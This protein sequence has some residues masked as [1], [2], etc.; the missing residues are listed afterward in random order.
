ME[1]AGEALRHL[2]L[3]VVVVAAAAVGERSCST[4]TASYVSLEPPLLVVPLAAGSRTGALA[5]AAGAFS[6]SVLADDQAEVAVRAAAPSSAD[7]LADQGIP[8]LDPPVGS[9]APGVAG[10]VATFWCELESAFE[11]GRTL[12]AVGRVRSAVVAE[13]GHGPLVRYERRY[14][15][16][17]GQIEVEAEAAYPL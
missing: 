16:L 8:V 7:K 3:A 9:A 1:A 10:S 14:R 4:A 6:V 13:G 5:Q 2:P 17:G 11:V 12:L 15:A